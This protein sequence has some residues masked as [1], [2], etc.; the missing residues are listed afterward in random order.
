MVRKENSLSVCRD[1]KTQE[2][3]WAERL[4]STHS[5]FIIKKQGQMASTLQ[6]VLPIYFDFRISVGKDDTSV[7]EQKKSN[8][9]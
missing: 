3:T 9:A 2:L 6:T 8:E 7:Q 5:V 4:S 1:R